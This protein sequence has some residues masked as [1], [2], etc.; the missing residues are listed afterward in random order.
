MAKMDKHVR[1]LLNNIAMLPSDMNFKCAD[2]DVA[3]PSLILKAWSSVLQKML[4]HS[5]KEIEARSCPVQSVSAI[6]T[7]MRHGTIVNFDEFSTGNMFRSYRLADEYKLGLLKQ[8]LFEKLKKIARTQPL[9]VIECADE[10]EII[11][12]AL[13]EVYVRVE[14]GAPVQIATLSPEAKVKILDYICLKKGTR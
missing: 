14:S 8:H 6:V 2:G 9:E 10:L 12:I 5:P 1:M 13:N 3:A 7:Y 4:E 11:N